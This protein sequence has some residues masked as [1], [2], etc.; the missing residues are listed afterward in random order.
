[1]KAQ[2]TRP[3]ATTGRVPLS[4]PGPAEELDRKDGNPIGYT[5][6]AFLDDETFKRLRKG[7]ANLIPDQ[8]R[9]GSHLWLLD[10]VAPFGGQEEMLKEVAAKVSNGSAFRTVVPKKDGTGMRAVEIGDGI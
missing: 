8:W 2:V 4:N 10:F 5:A 6:W 7:D 1:M 9:A 3:S